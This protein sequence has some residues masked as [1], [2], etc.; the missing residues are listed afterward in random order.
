[1]HR[2]EQDTR[3][4]DQAQYQVEVV[5]DEIGVLEAPEQKQVGADS[6]CQR[7]TGGR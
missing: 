4:S 5:D 7:D 2:S 1:M 6:Q 3:K